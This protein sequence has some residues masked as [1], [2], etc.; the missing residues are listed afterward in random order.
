MYKD[1]IE[2]L[3]SLYDGFIGFFNGKNNSFD[4]VFY[5]RKLVSEGTSSDD[6]LEMVQ[7]KYNVKIASEIDFLSYLNS[8]DQGNMFTISQSFI[9]NDGGGLKLECHFTRISKDMII[10]NI[11]SF[12]VDLAGDIDKLTKCF[13][14]SYIAAKSNNYLSLN[15]PFTLF[16]V[17]IDDFKHL[18]SRYGHMFGDMVLMEVSSVLKKTVGEDGFVARIGGDE[19]L[20]FQSLPA[21]YDSVYAAA[22]RIGHAVRDIQ[23]A[24]IKNKMITASVGTSTY[25]TD[26][27]NFDELLQKADRALTRSKKKGG[28]S[29][30]VYD[31]EKC[32]DAAIQNIQTNVNQMI[33]ID[34]DAYFTCL[35][36]FAEALNGDRSLEKNIEA[37]L[38]I[39][40]NFY[41]L[42]RIML[43]QANPD[44]NNIDKLHQWYNH[45]IKVKPVIPLNNDCIGL[46]REEMGEANKLKV[47]NFKPKPEFRL[48]DIFIADGTKATLAFE[49]MFEGKS[50]GLIKFDMLS[51]KRK[52]DDTEINS[53]TLATRILAIKLKREYETTKYQKELYYDK[54]T[55]AYNFNRWYSLVI[56]KADKNDDYAIMDIAIDDFRNITNVIGMKAINDILK[57]I[58]REI[59]KKKN[60]NIACR[61]SENSFMIY[62]RKTDKDSIEKLYNGVLNA[63]AK[64]KTR[65]KNTIHI[66]AGVYV[67]SGRE[68]LQTAVDKAI[69]AGRHKIGTSSITYFDKVVYEEEKFKT[70]LELH[71]HDALEN[72]EFL[73]YLQPKF[74]PLTNEL[75]GA[76]ALSRWCY[77]GEKMLS[78]AVFIPF[79]EETGFIIE[80][81]YKVFENTCRFQREC[82]DKGYKA[83]PISV[84]VSRYV[85]DFDEYLGRI[86]EIRKRY[87]IDPSLIEIE[88][89]EGMFVSDANPIMDFME[90]AHKIGYHFSMDDFGTGYSNLASLATMNFETI[91]IDKSFI[92]DIENPKEGVILK[93]MITM[94]KTLNMKT[95]CEG[96][97]TKE[98]VDLLR[99][100]GCDIIQGY[101][102]SKPIPAN[103]FIDK[104]SSK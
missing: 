64:I 22:Q 81:D 35:T 60:K 46:W 93:T 61:R 14:K 44:E 97:E 17:D 18:N 82:L 32:S 88:I 83:V 68:T 51:D 53:L 52:W 40:G 75:V 54:T 65:T 94:I 30:V 9:Q 11:E 8:D 63:A 27:A 34:D 37:A 96:V 20:V 41:Q 1:L 36:T 100:I 3:L 99:S 89:T 7:D 24:S 86:E 84:N 70:A 95:L 31:P 26:A 71:M 39:L 19:F 92:K 91:K 43:I 77:K 104:Y 28:N 45:N 42:E 87:D 79:F 48:S 59:S 102:Y 16:L 29:F 5:D 6:F 103:E 21:N 47:S 73:L 56:N 76:E 101:F 33:Q 66:Q 74:N 38:A 80:L 72:N 62:T 10:L 2:S 69:A 4:K 23:S 12:K 98:Y 49:L 78:P 50:F 58:V 85:N 55:G 13:S 25:P 57:A 67:H 90:K 15:K